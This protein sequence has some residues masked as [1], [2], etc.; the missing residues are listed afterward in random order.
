MDHDQILEMVKRVRKACAEELKG[1]QHKI[2][3][4]KNGKLD[5]QD[6]EHLRKMKKEDVD[7]EENEVNETAYK[8][9]DGSIRVVDHKTPRKTGA[10]SHQAGTT[11]KHINKPTAGEKKAAKDIK[12]GIAGYRD[13]VAMLKSAE[14][15]GALKKEDVELTLEDIEYIMESEDFQQL[16][17]LSKNT[18]K[19]YVK[20]A[21]KNWQAHNEKQHGLEGARSMINQLSAGAPGGG[22]QHIRGTLPGSGTVNTARGDVGDKL[23]KHMPE[24]HKQ[25]V[26]M[27]KK[28]QADRVETKRLMNKRSEGI[29]GAE[30]RIR[31]MKPA[32]YKNEQVEY[33]DEAKAPSGSPF[34]KDYKSQMRDDERTS[35]RTYHDIKKTSTGTVYTKQSDPEG[36]S[37]GTGDDAAKAAEP[38]E[39]RGRGRPVG[40]KSGARQAGSASKTDYRGFVTHTLNLPASK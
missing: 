7:L 8:N 3:M 33:V 4:N 35:T 13:R 14:A 34:S 22:K 29:R 6:F 20:K 2:D 15:R 17:E 19:S 21:E 1:K 25:L 24:L 40:S 5:A 27:H 39:K 11:M 16:D 31:K 36:Y 10:G 9:P 28:L 38:K 30:K 37:K 12:P 23:K 18:L 26:K 32:T